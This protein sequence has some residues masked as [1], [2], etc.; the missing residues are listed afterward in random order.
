MS[1]ADKEAS[2]QTGIGNTQPCHTATPR[3]HFRRQYFEY[4]VDHLIQPLTN[5]S[6]VSKGDMKRYVELEAMLITE[7]CNVDVA[8]KYPEI[9]THK[10]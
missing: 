3:D 4:Y 10:L 2:Q 5:M 8:D 6:D 9:D 1:A 7:A